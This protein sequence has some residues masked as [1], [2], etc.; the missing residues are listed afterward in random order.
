MLCVF[1]ACAAP[2]AVLSD[3]ALLPSPTLSP[4]LSPSLSPTPSPTLLPSPSPTPLPTPKITDEWYVERTAEMRDYMARY[5]GY[6]NEAALEE[7]LCS[8]EIDP[9]KPMVALTFDDGPIEG[10]T[11]R[12]VDIL[13]ANGA[14]AT[15]FVLGART[16][17]AGTTALLQSILGHGNEIGNHTWSHAALPSCNIPDMT[18]QILRTND[19]VFAAVGYTVRS[20]RPPGGKYDHIVLHE[21]KKLGMPV[22]LWA[23]SGNVHE[24]D[25][26]Q[27]AENVFV[28]QVNGKA[29]ESGD[30]ILLHD[31]KPH[32]VDA[33]ALL[34]PRLVE[35]GYQLVTVQELLHLSDR[36]VLPGEVYRK[37]N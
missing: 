3:A 13:A 25:P 4:S 20:L 6:E 10:V 9:D 27:I 21:A 37:Q 12:I 16:K 11:D 23:Q 17:A 34:V 18:G 7:A 36:G 28:Q 26:A 22:V 33:V 32:M 19:A 24:Q 14:R 29:L 30:I 8:F 5:G 1:S 2:E 15:F 31:T 35:A